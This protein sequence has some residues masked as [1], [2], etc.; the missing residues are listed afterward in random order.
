MGSQPSTLPPRGNRLS[1]SDHHG[2]QFGDYEL[3]ERIG[4]GGM[5]LVY[6]ARQHNPNRLVAIKMILAG[7]SPAN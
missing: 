7:G 5:G 3:L 2:G 6:K 4:Q 1:T